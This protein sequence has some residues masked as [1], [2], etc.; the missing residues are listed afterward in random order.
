MVKYNELIKYLK[1]QGCMLLR[2]GSKHDIWIHKDK[3]SSVPRHPQINKLTCWA[4]CKQLEIAKFPP[5]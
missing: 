2:N 5:H 3:Q 4:I 1:K